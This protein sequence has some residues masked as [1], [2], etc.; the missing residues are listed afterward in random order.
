MTFRWFTGLFRRSALRHDLALRVD[1]DA[2]ATLNSATQAVKLILARRRELDRTGQADRPLV[3][4]AGETHITPAHYIHHMLVLKGLLAA[5]QKVAVGNESPD[6]L[7]QLFSVVAGRSPDTEGKDALLRLDP[8]GSLSVRWR[9]VMVGKDAGYSCFSF[10]RFLLRHGVPFR[11]VDAARDREEKY[12]D[13]KDRPSAQHMKVCLGDVVENVPIDSGPG[14]YVR[15][16]HMAHRISE[17]AE[18]TDARIVFLRC[19]N[20]HVAGQVDT[21]DGRLVYEPR[22]SLSALFRSLHLPF[23]ALL[24]DRNVPADHGLARQEKFSIGAPGDVLAICDPPL[25]SEMYRAQGLCLVDNA[26]DEKVYVNALARRTGL[27][28]IMVSSGRR[29]KE[30]MRAWR[31]LVAARPKWEDSLPPPR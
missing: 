28:E 15:N 19:G 11:C 16:H 4:L 13:H 22:H 7:H 24:A 10:Y 21:R 14:M 27:K 5:G 20:A 9:L 1:A 6:D 31:D 18:A 2:A 30:E 12:V 25:P 17:F 23:F 8:G 29:K 3:V 26:A